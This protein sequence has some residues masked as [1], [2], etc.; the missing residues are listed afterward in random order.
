MVE[1]KQM[2]TVKVVAAIICDDMKEKNKIFATARGYGDLKGG[3]EFPGGKVES[4]ETPQQGLKRN[5]RRTGYGN[6]SRKTD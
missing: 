5:H 6:H 3:W 4:G 1:E 2:K